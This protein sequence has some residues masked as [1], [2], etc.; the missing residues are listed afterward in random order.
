MGKEIDLETRFEAE[1]LY[2]IDGLTYEQVAART[3]VSVSQLKNWAAAGGWREK[4]AEYRQSQ[5]TNRVK[6][7]RLRQL[8]LDQALG[9]ADPQAVYAAVRVQQ[10]AA[11]LEQQRR[12]EA[13]ASTIVAEVDRPKIFLECLEFIAERLKETDPEG[14]RILARNFEGLVDAFKKNLSTNYKSE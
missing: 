13:E 14:L 3:G 10:M 8:M 9:S 6:V 5:S 12:T 11:R 1:D 4:R 2:I 7:E